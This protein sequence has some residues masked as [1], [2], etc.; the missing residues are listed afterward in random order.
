M[1][2]SS[3]GDELGDE[4][5]SFRGLSDSIEVHRHRVGAPS[6]SIVHGIRR[7]VSNISLSSLLSAPHASPEGGAVEGGLDVGGANGPV[8]GGCLASVVGREAPGIDDCLDS[9][10]GGVA[11]LG[12]GGAVSDLGVGGASD[13]VAGSPSSVVEGDASGCVS[14]SVVGVK[15]A[16]QDSCQLPAFSITLTRGPTRLPSMHASA[17]VPV[18]SVHDEGA[19]REVLVY[20]DYAGL[21]SSW[22]G[23][24]GL[25]ST[26]PDASVPSTSLHGGSLPSAHAMPGSTLMPHVGV[27]GT[28]SPS[29]GSRYQPLVSQGSERTEGGG[30]SEGRGRSHDRTGRVSRVPSVPRLLRGT[31]ARSVSSGLSPE[32]GRD[33][34]RSSE[35]LPDDFVAVKTKPPSTRGYRGRGRRGS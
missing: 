30:G 14:S 26:V 27:R 32:T 35:R 13:L 23:S 31:R 21:L 7:K 18:V 16:V 2:D 5:G 33:P 24:H 12:L 15:P 10:A 17:S 4:G 8:I 19:R 3:S 28:P 20:A 34:S 25:L 22:R 6:D 9:V 11:V 1:V 29:L